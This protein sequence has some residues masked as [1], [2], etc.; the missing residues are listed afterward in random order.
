VLLLADVIYLPTFLLVD[1]RYAVLHAGEH[2]AM[3]NICVLCP[4]TAVMW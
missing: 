1:T 3:L 2:T 4:L